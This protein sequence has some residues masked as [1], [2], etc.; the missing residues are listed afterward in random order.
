MTKTDDAFM[1]GLIYGWACRVENGSA[2]DLEE[3]VKDM[4]TF[5]RR[6]ARR[7]GVTI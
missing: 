1:S 3:A 2:D 7:A 6:M 5:S 4:K